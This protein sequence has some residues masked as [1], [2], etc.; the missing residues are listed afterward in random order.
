MKTLFWILILFIN[1]ALGQTYSEHDLGRLEYAETE[2]RLG[3]MEND[4]KRVA[5]AYYIRG[6]IKATY[7]E[8][9]ESNAWFIK[10]LRIQES[11][12]DYEGAVKSCRELSTNALVAHR[13]KQFLY[14]L[15]RAEDFYKKSGS[16]EVLLDLNESRANFFITSWKD[17]PLYAK[18]NFDSAVYYLFKMIRVE[19]PVTRADSL[20]FAGVYF[21]IASCYLHLKKK[22]AIDYLKIHES[23]NCLSDRRI[24]LNYMAQVTYY[25]MFEDFAQAKIYFGKA[26]R[27]YRALKNVDKAMEL[28]FH[29]MMILYWTHIDKRP[30]I[31]SQNQGIVTQIGLDLARER[32]ATNELNMGFQLQTQEAR[33]LEKDKQISLQNRNIQILILGIV[34]TIVAGALFYRLLQVNKKLVNRNALLVEE[35]NH[36]VKNNFQL[37]SNLLILQEGELADQNSKKALEETQQRIDSLAIVHSYLYGHDLLEKVDM[38]E[39]LSELVT[40]LLHIYR[41]DDTDLTLEVQASLM[42]SNTAILLGLITNEWGINICKHALAKTT[43]RRLKVSLSRHSSIWKLAMD[44]FGKSGI[45]VVENSSFGMN[46]ISKLVQQLNGEMKYNEYQNL[47]EIVFSDIPE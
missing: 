26:F 33:I 38:R 16:K 18:P 23:Y 36:R 12:K 11:I 43:A 17:N 20:H 1:T 44:D 10:G 9:A 6:K 25:C 42:N 13:S 46:L 30:E 19:S 7:N 5:N 41:L 22:E 15:N 31:A 45:E 34:V 8:V 29:Q 2:E 32:E 24:A 4:F 21:R 47:S 35:V 28:E 40:R 39:F 37:L 27:K 3:K 14:W